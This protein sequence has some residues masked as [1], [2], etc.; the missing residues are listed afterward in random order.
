MMSINFAIDPGISRFVLFISCL[1]GGGGGGRRKS[2][3]N[4][5]CATKLLMFGTE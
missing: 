5:H 4:V 3:H 2:Q 1:G